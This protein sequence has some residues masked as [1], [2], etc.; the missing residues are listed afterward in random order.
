[1]PPPMRDGNRTSNRRSSANAA[2]VS[3]TYVVAAHADVNP[4]IVTDAAGTDA[5]PST[6]QIQYD[7]A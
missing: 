5:S 7:S 4:P 2:S 6:T 1:M 3:T